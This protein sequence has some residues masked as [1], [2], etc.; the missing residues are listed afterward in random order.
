M[1]VGGGT[2][3]GRLG[4][5]SRARWDRYKGGGHERRR[6]QRPHSEVSQGAR[7]DPPARDRKGGPP[8][9]GGGP[10]QRQGDLPRP[11]DGDARRHRL[12]P[13]DQRR[14]RAGI[15]RASHGLDAGGRQSTVTPL[16]LI[17]VAHLS[18]SLLTNWARYSGVALFALGP[19]QL[20]AVN[21]VI[22]DCLLAFV[23][24]EPVDELLAKLL[25]HMRM[26]GRVN[27]DDTV[28]VEQQFVSLHRDDEVGLVLE[29]NPRAAVRHNI[30]SAGCCYVER[31]TH[32]LPNRFVPG[33]SLLLDV[34]AD[35]L[36]EIDFRNVRAGVVAARDEGC[37][38]GLNG[39]Q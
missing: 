2:P 12:L 6:L 11:R 5:E 30:G 20:L 17:G 25:L 15:S 22:G 34:D 13:R 32:A 36:P 26:L 18:I 14:N 21:L 3:Q 29:R 16:A 27:Q 19:E 33:P 37:T 24:N 4:Q 7:R 1:A 23:R 9:P 35:A 8:G 38:L 39:F 10:A 28:L 31:G